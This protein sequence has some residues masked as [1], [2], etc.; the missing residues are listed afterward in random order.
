VEPDPDFNEAATHAALAVG[1]EPPER[2]GF[3]ELDGCS[4]FDLVTA[5]NDSFSH[6]LTSEA[7]AGG[8]LQAFAALRPGGVLFIE[9]PNFLWILKNYQAPVPLRAAV[10]NGEVVLQREHEIDYHAATFTTIEHYRLLCGGSEQ[11]VRLRHVYAM[12]S[13]PELEHQLRSAGFA[14]V[15]TYGSYAARAAEPI[16]GSR[17]LIAAERPAR[18]AR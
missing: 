18:G 17:M 9:V 1:Y 5:I 14:N 16:S 13:L 10:P 15:E 12:T 3:T 8:L 4:D 7:R 2:A 6:L 11:R